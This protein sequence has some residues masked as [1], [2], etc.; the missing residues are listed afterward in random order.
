MSVHCNVNI[1]GTS[2]EGFAI[3]YNS[4]VKNFR[5][6]GLCHVFANFYEGFQV[7]V[8]VARDLALL[9]YKYT[10][11]HGSFLPWE[12][13]FLSSGT[14]KRGQQYYLI[15][16]LYIPITFEPTMQ[17]KNHVNMLAS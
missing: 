3:L 5:F 8:G 11:E 10:M 16:I 6:A 7:S 1:V 4:G 17:F 15:V 13:G 12:L 2:Q 14:S 9:A